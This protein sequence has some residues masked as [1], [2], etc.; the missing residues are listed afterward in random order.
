[1]S[2]LIGRRN[3]R[4]KQGLAELPGHARALPYV[5]FIDI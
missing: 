2:R 5:I 3:T 4:C 1:M